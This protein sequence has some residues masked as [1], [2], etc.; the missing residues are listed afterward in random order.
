MDWKTNKADAGP[1]ALINAQMHP[2]GPLA[3]EPCSQ[4]TRSILL[5]HISDDQIADVYGALISIMFTRRS[6]ADVSHSLAASAVLFA[7]DGAH[8]ACTPTEIQFSV[9]FVHF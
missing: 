5:S 7:P 3:R 1:F 4:D 6:M 8:M 2:S 9:G